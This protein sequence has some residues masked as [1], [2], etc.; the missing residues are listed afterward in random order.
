MGLFK[1]SDTKSS[2]D[3][4]KT[5]IAESCT[6]TGDLQLAGSL[7]VDG[8][9]EGSVQTALDISVGQNGQINGLVQARVIYLSGCLEG[10]VRCQGLEVLSNGRFLGE[11]ISGELT[12]ERGGKFIGQSFEQ[13]DADTTALFD[14]EVGQIESKKTE[15]EK[16]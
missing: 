14:G 7:H 1:S 3:G 2:G 8:R 4:G 13:P 11:L 12:I 10:K 15:N 6:I 5:I 16:V 9:I